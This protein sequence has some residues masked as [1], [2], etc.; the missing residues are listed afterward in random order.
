MGT[1]ISNNSNKISTY[2]SSIPQR[3]V[4]VLVADFLI[5]F[6]LPI[7]QP[8]VDQ[9][10]SSFAKGRRHV[11]CKQVRAVALV[12]LSKTETPDALAL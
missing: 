11:V 12:R 4:K 7:G 8:D 5:D 9:A 2:S 6:N 3:L 10:G 1:F